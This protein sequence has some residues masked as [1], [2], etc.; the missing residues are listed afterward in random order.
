MFPE[1]RDRTTALSVFAFVA[2]GG[3]TLGL[4]LGGVITDLLS[5]HWIFFINVPVGAATLILGKRLIEDQ[6][7]I[8]IGQGA[9]IA[10]ALLVTTAPMLTVYALVNA[11][12]A[13]W[14]SPL[15]VGPLVGAL[16]VVGLFVVVERRV[17]APL[18]PLRIFRHRNLV[19]A[20][21]VRALFPMGGFGFNFIG[22][23]YFQHVLGYSALG[24]GLAFLPSSALTGFFCLA[25]TPGLARRFGPKALVVTGVALVTVGL[26]AFAPVPVNA[27]YVTDILPTMILT[28]AGFG[29]LFMPSVSIAMSDVAPSE[30]GLA[31]GLTNVA[32]QLGAAIGV[33]AM[34][35]VST[36]RTRQLLSEHKPVPVALTGGYRLALLV[37]AGCTT[38]S[39]LAA[40]TLLRSRARGDHQHTPR[41]RHLHPAGLRTRPHIQ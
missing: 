3:A 34:A 29:L 23:L 37:A 2:I 31:S 27:K 20:T 16:V 32:V 10:G 39:L 22:A 4:V 12:T 19:S 6:P 40:I 35:T 18:V 8:G 5:W 7:G 41:R 17:Q 21:V 9:D 1:P 26:L 11:A 13:G 15:T 24:T 28:G 36:A 25:L 33:A 14:A 30:A 38:M